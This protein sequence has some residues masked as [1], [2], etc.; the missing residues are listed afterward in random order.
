MTVI[1]S[2][3][4][5]IAVSLTRFSSNQNKDRS[6]KSLISIIPLT[7][8]QDARTKEAEVVGDLK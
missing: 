6:Q 7:L 5:H 1:V 3:A 8:L 2:H 4:P